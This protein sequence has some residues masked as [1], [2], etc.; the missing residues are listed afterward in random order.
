MKIFFNWRRANAA[1]E[2]TGDGPRK[3]RRWV[4]LIAL[5]VAVVLLIGSGCASPAPA[6]AWRPNR[7]AAVEGMITHRAILTARGRQFTLNGYLATSATGDR[8]LI[9]TEMFGQVLADALVKSDGSVHV[10]RASRVLRPAW[11]THFVVGDMLCIFGPPPAGEC[12]VEQVSADHYVISRRW[13]SLDLRV[14]ETKPGPQPRELFEAIPN[15][16]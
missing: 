5:A 15:A 11:I 1:V 7:P 2:A 4:I 6:P 16:K 3:Q 14:V 10:M 8:R 9:V 13:Y 12:P